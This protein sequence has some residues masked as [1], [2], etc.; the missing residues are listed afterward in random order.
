[1]TYEPLDDDVREERTLRL[2]D[3]RVPLTAWLILER[4]LCRC[5]PD[6]CLCTCGWDD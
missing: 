4:A 2:A 6:A 1:M 5:E 3:S